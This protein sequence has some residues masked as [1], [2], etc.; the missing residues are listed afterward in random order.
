MTN[1]SSPATRDSNSRLS[2][3]LKA[4]FVIK[5]EWLIIF[6]LIVQHYGDE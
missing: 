6:P 1:Y 2:D 4:I 5:D 3:F